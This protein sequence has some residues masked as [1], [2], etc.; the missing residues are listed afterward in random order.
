MDIIC[1]YDYDFVFHCKPSEEIAP[2][3]PAMRPTANQR[4]STVN[5]LHY[6][7][8]CWTIHAPAPA[9]LPLTRYADVSRDAFR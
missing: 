6:K 5:R 4:L 3:Q 8:V 7:D 9:A 2:L 1:F